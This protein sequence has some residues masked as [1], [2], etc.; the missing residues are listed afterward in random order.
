[1][2]DFCR[3]VLA[4]RDPLRSAT[5]D[6]PGLLGQQWPLRHSGSAGA[7]LRPIR[8]AGRTA[9]LRQR[10]PRRPRRPSDRRCRRRAVVQPR[11]SSYPQRTRTPNRMCDGQRRYRSGATQVRSYQRRRRRDLRRFLARPSSRRSAHSSSLTCC[12]RVAV[13]DCA[14][15]ANV[16]RPLWGRLA[17]DGCDPITD[18]MTNRSRRI[19]R[20]CPTSVPVRPGKPLGQLPHRAVPAI[21][22]HEIS[23][24]QHTFTA[25]VRHGGLKARIVAGHADQLGA[26]T[27]WAQD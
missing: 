24:P 16:A 7:G 3:P 26:T 14:N 8:R 17:V 19:D 9:A 25:R 21:A 10:A 18:I 4:H 5:T 22:R 6:P 27:N 15:A 23:A 12:Q 20:R 2:V 13:I 1:M 11:A